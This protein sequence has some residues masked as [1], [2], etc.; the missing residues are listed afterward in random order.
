MMNYIYDVSKYKLIG[1]PVW[2][3][4][5]CFWQSEFNLC[6]QGF[7]CMPK[8][9]KLLSFVDCVEFMLAAKAFD[10]DTQVGLGMK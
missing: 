4:E 1:N 10:V 7:L 3:I 8:R 2:S 9:T 6:K 5:S